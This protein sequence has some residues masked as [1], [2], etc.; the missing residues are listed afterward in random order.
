MENN[1]DLN[2]Q[3]KYLTFNSVSDI[4]RFVLF[5]DIPIKFVLLQDLSQ[6][7]CKTKSVH[8]VNVSWMTCPSNAA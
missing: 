8:P 3:F 4:Y 6:V 1:F 7:T 2:I 5:T